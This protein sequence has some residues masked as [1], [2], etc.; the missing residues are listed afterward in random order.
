V[1]LQCVRRIAASQPAAD[2]GGEK[3]DAPEDSLDVIL[4]DFELRAD[5]LQGK[6]AKVSTNHVGLAD[7]G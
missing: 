6:E 2:C 4:F 7:N 5:W 3:E 1:N